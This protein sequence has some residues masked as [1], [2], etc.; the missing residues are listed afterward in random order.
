MNE[1]QE[2]GTPED[3]G[4]EEKKSGVSL[5]TAGLFLALVIIVLIFIMIFVRGCTV[6]KESGK[7]VSVQSQDEVV[8]SEDTK[9]LTTEEKSTESAEDSKDV[10]EN[11]VESIESGAEKEGKIDSDNNIQDSAT[12]KE[13]DNGVSSEVTKQEGLIKTELPTLGEVLETSV[14]VSGKEVYRLEGA[15]YV[16]SLNLIFPN[17]EG[18]DIIKYLCSKKTYDAVAQGDTIK[19]SYQLD[20]SGA[21][22]ISSIS[23]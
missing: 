16:Y 17:G 20:E 3:N 14:V 1:E 5:K 8:M 18:Y 21:I 13:S 2:W 6:S 4:V 9:S 22:S 23:K 12:T 7:D 15:T 11:Q 19:V 10:Q